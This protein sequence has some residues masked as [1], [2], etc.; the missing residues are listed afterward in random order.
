MLSLIKKLDRV[1]FNPIVLLKEKGPLSIELGKI[2]V[3]VFFEKTITVVPYNRSI[4]EINSIKQYLLIL[5]SLRKIKY[6]IKKTD[7]D[8]VHIN[9]MMMYP[10]ALP[11][12]K[13]GKK[14]VVHVREHWPKGEHMI[15]FKIAR[16][17]IE[18]YSN[19][20]IA[21]NGTSAEIIGIPH[22]TEVVYNWVDFDDRNKNIDLNKLFGEDVKS[23]KI[24]LF[25]GGTQ[26]IKGALEVV[27][28]FSNQ[29][30]NKEARLLFVGCDKKEI[31]I[32]GFKGII[33]N[34]L[35]FFNYYT[36][37][38]KIKLIAQKD[39]R[40]IFL[41]S[42]NQVKSLIEQSYCVVSFFTI[43]HANSPIAEAT[44]LGKP[45][46]AVDTPEAKD[47]SDNGKAALL[48]NMNNKEEF[49]SKIIFALENEK[50]INYNAIDGMR[51]IQE[52]FDP[53]INSKL[54]NTIYMDLIKSSNKVVRGY[55]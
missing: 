5:L 21:I 18:K 49:K 52:K 15:Q 22:K 8:I 48:F 9:T 31:D 14:V 4:L 35:H 37:S 54:Q 45:S 33:K 42:T 34:I 17:F 24:I 47:Y 10:Y 53:A 1:H 40:I 20:I 3:T 27:D 25:L 50:L 39:D 38:D 30:H 28:V 26:R 55:V 12:Y 23:L 19:K 29:I 46:I 36:Y 32:Q 51:N 11:A 43:P 6:W 2:G 41:P 44:W 13:L 16:R 7:A